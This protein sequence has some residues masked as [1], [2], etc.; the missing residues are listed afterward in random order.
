MTWLPSSYATQYRIK[1][2]EEKTT[3]HKYITTRDTFAQ[4]PNLKVNTS[5]EIGIAVDE[6]EFGQSDNYAIFIVKTTNGM[7]VAFIRIF[8]F[9]LI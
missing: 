2:T 7:T 8:F 6:S 3:N 5:Y 9:V 4:I 1:Y